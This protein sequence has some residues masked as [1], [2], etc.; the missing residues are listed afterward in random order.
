MKEALED[1][2]GCTLL[3]AV[4]RPMFGV[5]GAAVER[6]GLGAWGL[7]FRVLGSRV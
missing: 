1:E 6:E 3:I 7:V 2:I 5:L 4:R